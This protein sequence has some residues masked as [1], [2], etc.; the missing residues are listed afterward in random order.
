VLRGI[1]NF[2]NG[3]LAL[4]TRLR[5]RA[6]Q[7]QAAA[8]VQGG[9]KALGSTGP[10]NQDI[11]DLDRRCAG[12]VDVD[13]TDRSDSFRRMHIS[14]SHPVNS[15]RRLHSL[16]HSSRAGA[17]CTRLVF[18]DVPVV[19][20]ADD[21]QQSFHV[22]CLTATVGRSLALIRMMRRE[23]S[24]RSPEIKIDRQTVSQLARTR[25]NFIDH[26]SRHHSIGGRGAR[27]PVGT[28]AQR[29]VMTNGW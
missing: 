24:A 5:Q 20:R 23:K 16:A 22:A 1:T 3:A 7:A 19:H 29:R 17:M 15:P 8:M 25:E 14:M 10:A 26:Q 12:D 21:M 13:R 9:S 11:V 6:T 28:M 4:L 2:G 18:G 27:C